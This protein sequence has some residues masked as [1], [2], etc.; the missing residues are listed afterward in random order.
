MFF[1]KSSPPQCA[2]GWRGAPECRT[3]MTAPGWAR[4][5]FPV[6]LR[7]PSGASLKDIAFVEHLDR[8]AQGGGI[9]PRRA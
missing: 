1:E 4:W 3:S 5:S 6:M 9:P 8:L 2:M 7:V